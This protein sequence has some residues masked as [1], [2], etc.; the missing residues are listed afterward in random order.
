MIATRLQAPTWRERFR[1]STAAGLGFLGPGLFWMTEFHIL[2]FMLATAIEV[3][4]F[5]V[6]LSVPP[7]ISRSKELPKIN[8]SPLWIM[9]SLPASLVLTDA[10][11]GAWPFGG[12]PIALVSQTQ[13][14]GPLTEVARL[15]GT[16]AITALIG[17]VGVAG[18]ALA[19]RQ[20]R[21]AA[22]STAL[23]MS[24]V[25]AGSLAPNGKSVG[26]LE[27]AIVQGGGERGTRAI[28]TSGE[29]VVNA[30]LAASVD[31]PKGVD[32]V[33]WPEDVIELEGSV[34]DSPADRGMGELAKRLDAPL[35]GG[36]FEIHPEGNRNA[37]VVWNA[38]GELIDRY[39]KNQRVPFGEYV[40]FR[41][42]IASLAD[43]SAIPAD[44]IAGEGPGL[45]KTSAGDI[46]VVI[47]YE[48]FFARRARD[49]MSQGAE[50]LYVPTNATS[51]STTQMPAL[52]LG[53]ARLRAIETGR[54]VVQAAP[55]GFS[56][57]IDPDGK[58]MSHT[59]LGTRSVLTERVQRR[60]GSTLYTRI[61]DGPLVVTA[62]LSV[63]FSLLMARRRS[64]G[65]E[66][67]KVISLT[68]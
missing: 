65:M 34:K 2:G 21:L 43:V 15:G 40:P 11:R 4:L 59:D 24:V 58:I 39:E 26:T 18:V 64:Q 46:G 60:S 54:F 33:V 51:Y 10:F 50:L 37:A 55:T 42:L 36:I 23:I 12:V 67:I 62:L 68:E 5:A 6:V 16:L 47:S 14:G 29:D 38:K 41:S 63:A 27:V 8:P 19:T 1:Q 66:E 3:F 61:G 7:L 32:L 52:E 17:L 28:N 30:H 20:V 9:V 25:I 31:I 56:G 53:A 22:M 45:L 49:A 44:A 35:A 48:V 57:F 13:I